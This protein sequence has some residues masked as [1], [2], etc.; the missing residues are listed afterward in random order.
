MIRYA[1]FIYIHH[2]NLG[3]RR[4]PE[5]NLSNLMRHRLREGHDMLFWPTNHFDRVILKLTK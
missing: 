5:N 2:I 3:E 1:H 4:S